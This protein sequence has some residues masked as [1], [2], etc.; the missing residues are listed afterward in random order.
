M[1]PK[2]KAYYI[3]YEKNIPCPR[4][5]HLERKHVNFIN[6]AVD[7][8]IFNLELYGSY[9]PPFW[10]EGSLGD[11]VLRIIFILLERHKMDP[12]G[13]SFNDVARETLEQMEWKDQQYLKNHIYSIAK[14]VY[15]KLKKIENSSKSDDSQKKAK[16]CSH[17]NLRVINMYEYVRKYECMNCGEIFVCK[18]E[19]SWAL[20]YLPHQ[21]VRE[22]QEYMGKDGRNRKIHIRENIC[23][24]CRGIK[25]P[26][27]P[28]KYG[29]N[30]F[31]K[32]H[33]YDIEKRAIEMMVEYD[34]SP[35][36]PKVDKKLREAFIKKAMEEK[37]AEIERNNIRRRRPIKKM[38]K[39]QFISLK[40]SDL[41]LNNI[42]TPDSD[43]VDIINFA[44]SF[45][46]Y[47]YW[48]SFKLCAQVASKVINYWMKNSRFNCSLTEL[49]TA[50]FFWQ[51]VSR[52]CGMVEG[53]EEL[54]FALLNAI[55]E[56][57]INRELD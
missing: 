12:N 57:V 9:F 32:E 30:K 45:N 52:H 28:K 53:E 4:C 46:G 17:D 42:P 41:N 29:P 33:W 24:R 48:G 54:V 19:N 34:I 36:D 51:R 16:E 56:K 11:H 38:K 21:A 26:L 27:A 31:Y 25:E 49:R 3:P 47:K 5:G 1:C 43:W 35:V 10:Y 44:L 40:N 14:K 13:K 7:S 23:F 15:K 6:K 8:A 2:C 22:G 37:R 18:C 20:R 39:I 55:R 50:L